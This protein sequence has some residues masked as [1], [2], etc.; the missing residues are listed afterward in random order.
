MQNVSNN[1]AQKMFWQQCRE[2]QQGHR[3]AEFCV[4]MVSIHMT[5]KEFNTSYRKVTATVYDFLMAATKAT[6]SAS[7]SVDRCGSI[8]P[9]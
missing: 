9:G 4:K 1:G 5:S 2:V 7:Y 6:H 3:H 8:Y